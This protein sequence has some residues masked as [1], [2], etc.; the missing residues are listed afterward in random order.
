[1]TEAEWLS[2][3]YPL[4]SMLYHLTSRRHQ[5]SDRK[6]PAV[7]CALLRVGRPLNT[8]RRGVPSAIEGAER[9]AD[10]Q[11]ADAERRRQSKADFRRGCLTASRMYR[12]T[13]P[14]FRRVGSVH[15]RQGTEASKV[16]P[17]SLTL[18]RRTPT[19]CRSGRFTTDTFSATSSATRSAPSPS[20]PRGAPSTGR[21]AGPADVRVARLLRDADP[22]RCASGRR[23][24][25]RRHPDHCRDPK[26]PHVRGCWVVDLVLGKE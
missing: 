20:I 10:G 22:R 24:R 15:I 25:Q 1:M 23:V 12:T 5:A 16:P 19:S 18:S 3:S 6:T 26:R 2:S 9:F 11:A 17:E 21:H 4:S 8:E 13:S 14:R 7:A